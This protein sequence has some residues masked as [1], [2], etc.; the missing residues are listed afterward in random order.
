MTKGGA[1]GLSYRML[2]RRN[3]MAWSLK[4]KVLMQAQGVLE[5]VKPSEPK[6]VVEVRTDKI[7]L[8][9]IY[10]GIPEEMLLSLA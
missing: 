6:V 10:Q 7:A 9:A 5:A 8:A 2:A 4:M 3:Y 1:I